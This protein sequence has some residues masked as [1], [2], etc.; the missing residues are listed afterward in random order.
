MTPRFDFPFAQASRR[1]AYRRHVIAAC[2]VAFGL[3]GLALAPADFAAAQQA[4]DSAATGSNDSGG[5]GFD[6][7]SSSKPIEIT[8]DNGIEWDKN[9]KA[10][11]ARGNALAVQG[12]QSI[13]GSVLNAYYSVD[14]NKIDR[15]TAEGNVVVKNSTETAYGDHAD[16]DAGKKLLVLTGKNL[17]S[18]TDKGD[19]VTARDAM[20]YWK[21]RDAVVAKGAVFIDRGD[22][23]IHADTATGYFH[24]DSA[25]KKVM[26]QIEAVGRVR[27]DTSKQTA[28]SDKMV[29]NLETKVAV[30][31][32]HVRINQ[33]NNV[34]TGD[35]AEI[36]TQ[37][38]ISRLLADKSKGGSG[39][40]KTVIGP[41]NKTDSNGST[42]QP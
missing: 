33:D 39:R 27:T 16:Y 42:T 35:K 34:F 6:F 12:D 10:Y 14:S 15:M 22:T 19:T 25:G 38:N 26:Y 9:Q 40:V 29:Y 11:T 18:V 31:T 17:K 2:A 28:W 24:R 21:D 8:A 30:L 3:G 37:T 5:G 7:N 4:T 32:G 13:A 36:N 20:E 23:K 1:R 41:K